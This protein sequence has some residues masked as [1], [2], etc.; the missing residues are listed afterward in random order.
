MKIL[1]KGLNRR[2]EMA[3]ESANLITGQLLLSNLS[4]KKKKE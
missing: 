2:F 3:E 1:L 4:N